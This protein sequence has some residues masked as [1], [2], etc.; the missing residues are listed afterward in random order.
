V[1]MPEARDVK[2]R[3]PCIPEAVLRRR[4]KMEV[5]MRR[6]LERDIELEL[7]DDYV[8]DLQ[9]NYD[10]PDDEKYDAI[11]EIWEGHNI[12]DYVDPD[13]MKRLEELEKEEEEREASGYYD[14]ED[15]DEDEEI[16]EVR[17]LAKQIR[18]KKALMKNESFMKKS[19]TK[20]KLPRTARKR[21]RSVSRLRSEMGELGVEMASDDEGHYTQ[22]AAEVVRSRPL[23]RM[24]E[25]SEG[26]VR[27]SSKLP[28]DQS[29]IRDVSVQRKTKKMAKKAQLPANRNARKGE[30]DRHIANVK[31]K[32]LFTGKR[33]IG[34]NSRR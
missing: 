15:T 26:R 13:I 29:G 22:A 19:S 27:S 20:P 25:D 14:I 33:S 32:H 10:L 31:P 2:E 21:E 5:D 3:P 7:G 11:P 12:A 23:K 30:G 4:E 1:A 28:R 16:Q 6:K 34:K 8:L 24:R 9:K 17:G 18:K